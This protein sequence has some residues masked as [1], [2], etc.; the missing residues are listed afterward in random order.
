MIRRLALDRSGALR[1]YAALALWLWAI[2][3]AFSAPDSGDAA[4]L[5]GR[6]APPN[7]F[8]LERLDLGSMDQEYGDPQK[9][10]SVDGNPLRLR[11]M[12]YPHGIGT[13]AA[14]ELE[15]DIPGGARR[16]LAMAGVDDERQ[17]QGSVVF[18]VWVDGKRAFASPVMHGGDEPRLV[19]VDLTGARRLRLVVTD[20]GD[21]IT[22]DHAGPARW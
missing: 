10:R 7:G 12:P 14:S 17:G 21:G 11:G 8:F 4:L 18:E 1:G 5:R 13:H 15:L 3:R 19:S 2:S 16:F 22:H 20:A 9:A 6:E